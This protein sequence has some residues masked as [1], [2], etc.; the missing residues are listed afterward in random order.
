MSE[1]HAAPT[2]DTNGSSLRRAS[3]CRAT[4]FTWSVFLVS[5]LLVT[6]TLHAAYEEG[7][8]RHIPWSGYWWPVA[9]GE[10]MGPLEKYDT[11]SGKRSLWWELQNK[12]PGP[13][14]PAWHG[15]C[16]GWSAAAV[17]EP[18]PKA[19]RLA[20]TRDDDGDLL[21]TVADQ[22][23]WF[24]ASHAFD[25]AN[26]YGDRFGDGE[27]SEDLQDIAPDRLWRLLKT[28][29]REQGIPLVMDLDAGEPVWNYPVFA[30]RIE[31]SA[32][33]QQPGWFDA[34][35]QLCAADDSVPPDFVGT[36]PHLQTYTFQFQM[37][38]GSVV[39]GSGRWTGSSVINHP[40]FAWYP[41]VPMPEN[42]EIDYQQVKQIIGN[43]TRSET[44][45]ETDPQNAMDWLGRRR[46]EDATG[47][48]DDLSALP[49]SPMQLVAAILNRQSS[50]ALDAHQSTFGTVT[51]DI[52]ER[53]SILGSSEESGYLYVLHVAPQ[54][55][56][57]LLWPAP[58]RDHRIVAG[59]SFR[60]P[61]PQHGHFVVTGPN[62]NHKVKVLITKRPLVLTG[63]DRRHPLSLHK[64]RLTK[65]IAAAGQPESVE[66]IQ[67]TWSGFGFRLCPTQRTQVAEMLRDHLHRKDVN[68]EP[69]IPMD[70]RQIFGRFAQDEITYYVRASE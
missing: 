5:T 46:L 26:Y 52:G 70:V 60:V 24:S 21:L 45:P 47:S 11:L 27:G 43:A 16:H 15:Y 57:T 40:D 1:L 6:Q 69:Q 10:L 31:Y 35:L 42:P 29:I 62:G 50:F 55:R 36:V 18:E 61:D 33:P 56:L 59:E 8:A 20:S 65:T 14:V 22:K 38:N 9:K 63:V 44:H 66:P 30:Y 32:N 28:F 37:Q 34:Y 23:G 51:R 3:R 58:G 4:L 39:L 41:Y 17:L 64:M 7:V 54:G 25:V 48:E 67:P 49:I 19:V 68:E 12:P 13:H 2:P 53:F